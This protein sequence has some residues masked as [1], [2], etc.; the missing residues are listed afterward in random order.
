VITTDDDKKER[1]FKIHILSFWSNVLSGRHALLG[2][3][4]TVTKGLML[5]MDGND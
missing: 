5:E 1:K 2:G 4:N 3:S